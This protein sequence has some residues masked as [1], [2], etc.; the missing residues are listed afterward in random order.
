MGLPEMT[1]PL[2]ESLIRARTD[3]VG[4]LAPADTTQYVPRPINSLEELVAIKGFDAKRIRRLR[5]FV[6]VYGDSAANVFTARPEVLR[7]LGVTDPLV[8][9]IINARS[10]ESFVR[11]FEALDQPVGDAFAGLLARHANLAGIDRTLFIQL[12]RAR[13]LKF[14]SSVFRVRSEGVVPYRGEGGNTASMRTELDVVLE[15]GERGRHKLTTVAWN[16][17]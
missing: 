17:R 10:D 5:A 13:Y 14:G 2:V 11:E 6:T 3:I 8:D 9:A 1:E 7:A 4:G 15:R 12:V 16:Q